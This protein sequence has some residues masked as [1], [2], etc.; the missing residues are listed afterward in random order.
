MMVL[1]YVGP[2]VVL[3]MASV[4][5][6]AFGFVMIVGRAPF[7]LTGRWIRAIKRGGK[8]EGPAPD[9]RAKP[10]TSRPPDATSP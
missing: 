5:A 7:R 6:A 8:K 3:P 1:A 9:R 10:S 2:E 4:V